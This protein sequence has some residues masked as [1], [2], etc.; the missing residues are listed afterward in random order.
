MSSELSGVDLAR[1]ALAAAREVAKK[2]GGPR[3]EGRR[4]PDPPTAVGTPP[5]LWGVA[6]LRWRQSLT[7][8][9]LNMSGMN[10]SRRSLASSGRFSSS[11]P[12]RKTS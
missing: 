3:H 4:C 6:S 12:K 1:Q 2:K 8:K 11:W 5:E 7:L 9:R 10:W